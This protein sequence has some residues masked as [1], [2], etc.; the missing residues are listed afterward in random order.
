MHFAMSDVA[1]TTVRRARCIGMAILLLVLSVRG[2]VRA[3]A[4][5][6]GS[7]VSPQ[8]ILVQADKVRNPTEGFRLIST[9]VEFRKGV[10]Q[11]RLRLQVYSKLDLATGQYR[12]LA[13]YL[14]P[15][16]DSGKMFLMNGNVMW[17]YDPATAASIR[18]SPQQRLI[19]QASNGDVLAVNLSKDY[20][21]QLVGVEEVKDA[22]HQSRQTWHLNLTATSPGA[23]YARVEYWVEQGSSYPVK[24]R[25]YSDSGRVLKAAYY[26]KFQS[27]LGGMR[28]SQVIIV[29]EL[30]PN[31]VTRMTFSDYERIPIP[32]NWFQHQFLPRLK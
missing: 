19:G 20:Q 32:E 22:D 26:L 25:F 27:E 10:E 30:D 7:S 6:Q 2:H 23:T 28:P 9:L 16:R 17:F 18:I 29:D 12:N 1:D 4:Q 31:L 15:T 13:R 24:G 5:E 11:D 8:E 3:A 14:E 21:A